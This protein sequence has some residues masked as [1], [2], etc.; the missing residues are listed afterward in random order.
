M[1]RVV[2]E[3]PMSCRE[4][5]RKIAAWR[6]LFGARPLVTI[7]GSWFTD[8]EEVVFPE[9]SQVL[10][11]GRKYV[12]ARVNGAE[13]RLDPSRCAP[14]ARCYIILEEVESGS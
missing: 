2:I 4:I 6:E 13:V 11:V 14:R 8:E 12:V 3:I 10:D 5:N 7:Q 1:T 9:G